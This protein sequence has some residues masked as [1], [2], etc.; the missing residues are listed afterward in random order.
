M[1]EVECRAVISG[2]QYEEFDETM[3]SNIDRECQHT[4]YFDAE[5]DLRLMHAPK[6][7]KL[8]LKTGKLHDNQRKEIEIITGEDVFRNYVELFKLIG[9]PIKCE[10]LRHR[11]Q[12]NINGFTYCL[13]YTENYGYILEIEKM[14]ETEEEAKL[15]EEIIKLKFKSL[16]IEITPKEIMNEMF[17]NYVEEKRSYL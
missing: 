12:F 6:Y 16:G 3:F 4:I 8:W 15:Y 7:C 2:A 5:N 11:K 14:C 13:D 1:I 10:F 17:K 9:F